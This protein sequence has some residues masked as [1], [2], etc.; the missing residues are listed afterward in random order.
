MSEITFEVVACLTLDRGKDRVSLKRGA[1][2]KLD[3]ENHDFDDR[4]LTR[5]I[6]DG[7]LRQLPLLE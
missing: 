1:R 3:T 6:R 7:K 5:A 2:L 4:Q